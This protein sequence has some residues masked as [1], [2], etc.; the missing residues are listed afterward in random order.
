MDHALPTSSSTPHS[1]PVGVSGIADAIHDG[2]QLAMASTSNLASEPAS[3]LSALVRD[4]ADAGGRLSTCRTP[5][6]VLALQ[7]SYALARGKAWLDS[8]CRCFERCVVDQGGW[9]QENERLVLP[10]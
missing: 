3:Y 9:Q 4:I 1:P 7:Q 8:A 6:D 5:F 2:F 10:D